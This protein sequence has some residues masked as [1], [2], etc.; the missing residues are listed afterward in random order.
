MSR[1]APWNVEINTWDGL[2]ITRPYGANLVSADTQSAK[3][4]VTGT[5]LRADSKS[6]ADLGYYVN[7][8]SVVW[9]TCLCSFP[10]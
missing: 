7:S 4:E 3:F 8:T 2:T 1:Q 5:G 9:H 10:H 6:T